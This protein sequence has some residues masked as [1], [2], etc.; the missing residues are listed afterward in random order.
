MSPSSRTIV[1]NFLA[2]S[3]KNYG[4]KIWGS[5]TTTQLQRVHKIQNLADKV[6]MGGGVKRDTSLLS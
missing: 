3:L 1:I 5:T 6:A 2:L 4:I